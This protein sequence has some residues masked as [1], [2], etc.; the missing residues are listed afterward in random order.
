ML[1]EERNLDSLIKELNDA[2]N[3][4]QVKNNYELRLSELNELIKNSDF[5]GALKI[6]N[7]KGG[8]INEL[9]R[10]IVNNYKDKIFMV[11]SEDLDLQ[12]EIKEKYFYMIDK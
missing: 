7:F 11:I 12:K 5:D 6:S 2:I 9:P 3:P 8:L 4:E 10:I 1:K